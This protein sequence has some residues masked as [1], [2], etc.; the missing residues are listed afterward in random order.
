MKYKLTKGLIVRKIK[1]LPVIWYLYKHYTESKLRHR[2]NSN[3]TSA[4]EVFNR[5]YKNN[6]WNNEESISGQGSE[7]KH[8]KEIVAKLP[9]FL[10]RHS[11]QSIL[12]A[13]C[14]DYNWMRRVQFEEIEYIGGDIVQELVDSNNDC[15]GKSNVSFKKI[16]IIEDKLPKVDLIFVR[17]C[18]VHFDNKSIFLFLNNLVN[19]EVKYLLATNFPIT[20]HNY[21]ITIGNWRPI[22]LQKKPYN[23]PK[24]IDILWEESEE[25]YGQFPDK[26][27]FL[28]RVKDIKS[29]L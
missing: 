1:D 26:S 3:N 4:E 12:D 13:P 24:E 2:L 28:W 14:G 8:T 22:N 23:L 6:D 15:F 11:V 18:L 16:N 7:L 17:D 27:L 19:S 10:T 21:D 20:N 29:V 25:T 9:N 5:I